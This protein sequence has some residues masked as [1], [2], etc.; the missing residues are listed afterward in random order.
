MAAS[1][2]E[3]HDGL[4]RYVIDPENGYA[5]VTGYNGTAEKLEIP[6]MF[7]DADTVAVAAGALKSVKGLSE[8]TVPGNVLAIGNGAFPPGAVIVSNNASYAQTW[9]RLNAHPFSRVF[10][11]DFRTGVVDFTGIREENFNRVSEKEVW[12]RALEA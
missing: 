11:M 1:G 4:W 8:I 9:A 2:Q 5:V 12:L 10:D 6:D 3:R 7:G